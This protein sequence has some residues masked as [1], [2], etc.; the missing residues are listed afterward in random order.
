MKFTI[1]LRGLPQRTNSAYWSVRIAPECKPTDAWHATPWENGW[2]ARRIE[3]G[4]V[5]EAPN[6][7]S[8]LRQLEIMYATEE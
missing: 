8:L 1:E 3:D 7:A 6:L 5:L 2:H 4:G